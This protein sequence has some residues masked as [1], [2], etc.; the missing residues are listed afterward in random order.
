MQGHSCGTVNALGYEFDSHSRKLN[1]E[2]FHF[3]S[4]VSRQ[5]AALSS[6]T[7]HVL[8]LEFGNWE[9]VLSRL[10]AGYSVKLQ[11]TKKWFETAMTAL[12]L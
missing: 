11:K 8:P 10:C 4:L 3:F 2:Y 6:A 7:Q 5:S 12:Q 9:M 1:I